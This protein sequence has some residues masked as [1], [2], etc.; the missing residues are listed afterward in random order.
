[1]VEKHVLRPS[2]GRLYLLLGV[3][4]AIGLVV[5]AVLYFTESGQVSYLPAGIAV[6]IT[7]PSAAAAFL[8]TLTY[9]YELGPDELII[10]KGILSKLSR[11]VPVANIDNLAVQRS[12]FDRLLGVGNI[13][14]DTP[15]GTGYELVFKHVEITALNEVVAEMKE[16]MA[17]HRGGIKR[18][19]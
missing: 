19:L 4:F 7:I 11:S 5:S 12:I 9:S 17:A 1:M 3:L 16:H 14:I 13:C 10:H 6:L 15:G 2:F 18:N 8:I